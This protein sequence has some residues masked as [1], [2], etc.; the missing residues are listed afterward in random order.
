MV[1]KKWIKNGFLEYL[2]G[3]K[4]G[5]ILFVPTKRQSLQIGEK[6]HVKNGLLNRM[7]QIPSQEQLSQ[8]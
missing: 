5:R 7:T 6:R 8:G 4:M 2:V 3:E 1:R